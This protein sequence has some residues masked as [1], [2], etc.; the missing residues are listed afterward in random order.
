MAG[1]SSENEALRAVMEGTAGETGE[2]FFRS[3]VRNLAQ[4]LDMHGAWVTEYLEKPNRLRALAFWNGDGFVDDYEYA[5]EGTPCE[6]V[7]AQRCLIHFPENIVELFPNDLDLPPASAVSYMGMPI[8]DEDGRI[9]GHLSVL[10]KKKM[11][12]EARTE[13]LFRIFGNR[14]AAELRRL[15]VERD[16]RTRE[17]ELS[18]LVDSAMDAIVELDEDLRVSLINNAGEKLFGCTAEEV[19]GEPFER[20]LSQRSVSKL[21]E[22][23]GTL[24]DLPEG[25]RYLWVHGGLEACTG[26]G[27]AFPAEAT[28]SCFQVEGHPRFTL[29]LRSVDE[30]VTAERRIRSLT[31][32]AEVLKEELRE[33]HDV[34]DIIGESAPMM[35][36]LGAVRQVAVTDS[37]VL[38]LGETGTGKELVAR[39]VHAA[40]LRRDK[41]LIKVN[42]AA[43]PASLME[44]EFFGHV[45]GAFTGATAAR[46]G[47]F[48]L[49]DG[50]TIF[51]DEVGDLPLD[52]QA[53]LLRVLQE[54]EF[55]PV[56]TSVGRKVDVRVIAATNRDLEE[57]SRAREFREDLFYRLNVF[58]I[59]VPA[60]RHRGNDVSLLA[61]AF[62][63]KYAR[64][65]GRKLEPLSADGMRRL[66]AYS[67]PGN[68]RELQNVIERAV[69]T[70]EEGHLNLGQALPDVGTGPEGVVPGNELDAD[71]GRI[72]TVVELKDLE[73]RNIIAALDSCNWKVAG[74]TGAAARLGMRP[75]TLSSR[76]KALEIRRRD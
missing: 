8:L 29:I 50:G 73:K 58:P 42:C 33:L 10:D 53:K 41:P 38:L 45:K 55:E 22:L 70:S 65:M 12:R 56:G 67:W 3:L 64:R 2:A 7:I 9:L 59:R 72:L 32:Q 36:A 5:V 37:T 57:A 44:S 68:V 40:S 17:Q 63:E 39:A 54:G 20:F 19:A 18:R 52:L 61:R 34:D 14:A 60:L 71:P 66:K 31:V 6:E 28:L 43:I 21:C 26:D 35:Q 74:S 76:M 46:E 23:I 4:V 13:A 15:R 51:L 62:A 75:S 48:A 25:A 49:A 1:M 24:D 11:P 69:I 47:R 16:L 27:E 30:R